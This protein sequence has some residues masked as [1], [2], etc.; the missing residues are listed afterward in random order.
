[1]IAKFADGTSA[2]GVTLIGADGPRSFV[3]QL[4]LGI[5]KADLKYAPF[6]ATRTTIRYA[7]REKALAVRKLHPIHAFCSQ[8]N[9]TFSW[10]N[11]MIS[12]V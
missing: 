7:D 6:V 12:S 1:M 5:E 9:G 4:L 10:I 11:I 3:R 8:P 2:V